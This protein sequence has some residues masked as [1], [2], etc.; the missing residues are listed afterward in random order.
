MFYED[1]AHKTGS[2]QMHSDDILEEFSLMDDFELQI[3]GGLTTLLLAP[4]R[5]IPLQEV[6]TIKLIIFLQSL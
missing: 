1:P 6:S 2:S 4:G 5:M 3:E